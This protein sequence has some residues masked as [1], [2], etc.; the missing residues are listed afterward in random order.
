[1]VEWG[2]HN[3]LSDPSLF[4]R[5][6]E[7]GLIYV[8]VYVDDI[9]I[10]GDCPK[11]IEQLIKKMNSVFALKILRL[12]YHFLGIEVTRDSTGMH[13]SQSKYISDLITKVGLQDCKPVKT[14]M[15]SASKLTKHAG[16]LFHDPTLYKSV[17]RA[18]NYVT[19]TRPDLAY[20]VS[21]LSHYMQNPTTLH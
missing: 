2:F 3:A 11:R 6:T 18:L 10:T 19:I 7:D 13:L 9:L 5:E 12:V 8:L 20:A 15:C 17:I 21:K 4:L 14:P 16:D 1:M